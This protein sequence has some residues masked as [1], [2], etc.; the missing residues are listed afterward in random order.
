LFLAPGSASIESVMQADVITVP[1]DMDQEEL[2]GVF[3]EHDLVAL[4]VVDD[5]GRMKGIVT[6]DDIVDVVREEATED[7]QKI[8]GTEALEAPYLEVGFLGMMQK[9]AGWLTVLFLLQFLS[10]SVVTYFEDSI[11][12]LAVLAAF[13]P[14]IISSGGN[15]GSQATTL[16]TRAMALQEVRLSDWLRVLSKEALMGLAL[17]LSLGTLGLLRILFWPGS[18]QDF[19]VHYVRLGL[20]VA[21]SV[22]GVVL[23]GT[24]SGSMLPLLLRRLGFDP[25]SA[26]APM[27]ATLVDLMGL[28]I[29]FNVARLYL[30]GAVL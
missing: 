6:I 18:E 20:T 21:T 15:S 26:S 25:A 13:I 27:V 19:G 9:R 22:L 12:E 10:I 14:L 24:I 30:G 16:V 8:G 5:A 1:E 23:W 7:I 17:G 2:A 4:P 11:A 3:A 28:I 29:Y